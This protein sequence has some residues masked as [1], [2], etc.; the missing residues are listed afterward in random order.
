MNSLKYVPICLILFT[1]SIHA[2]PP[3]PQTTETSTT[4][5]TSTTLKPT[6]SDYNMPIIIV[7]TVV[8]IV[9]T[10]VSIVMYLRYITTHES[11]PDEN[12]PLVRQLLD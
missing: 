2:I 8:L 1:L 6:K 3:E 5:G 9:I 12:I 7:L 11:A 4:M 10:L